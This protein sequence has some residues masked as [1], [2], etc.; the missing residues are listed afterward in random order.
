MTC[1]AGWQSSNDLKGEVR[2]TTWYDKQ[3][4]I[5]NPTTVSRYLGHVNQHNRT[6]LSQQ[7]QNVTIKREFAPI[8]LPAEL[9]T[10]C[11]LN[12]VHVYCI[13]G[14]SQVYRSTIYAKL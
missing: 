9:Q 7:Y 1:S 12:K 14:I 8:H 5:P 13:C 4:R 6:M 3:R 2:A 10:I 11:Y